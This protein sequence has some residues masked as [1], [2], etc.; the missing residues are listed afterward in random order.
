M[1]NSSNIPVDDSLVAHEKTARRRAYRS[2]VSWTPEGLASLVDRLEAFVREVPD[3]GWIGIYLPR[4]GEVDLRPAFAA[5]R[6]EGRNLALPVLKNGALTYAEATLH[7]DG[8][9]STADLA[10]ARGEIIPVSLAVV[11]G[12]AFDRKRIR[13]GRGG[14]H[15]DRYFA[16]F[17]RVSRIGVQVEAR[18]VDE[19][20][21][22]AHDLPMH[23][24]I[25]EAGAW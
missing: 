25:T 6:D 20:P 9:W 16:R 21:A 12:L 3:D 7:D 15:F 10:Q 23:A 14:G 2:A 24:V 13:L 17:P 1:P 4:S 19:L 5:W 11:P 18:M 8:S 22:E